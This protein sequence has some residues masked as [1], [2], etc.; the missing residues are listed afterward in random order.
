MAV[1]RLSSPEVSAGRPAQGPGLVLAGSCSQATLAQVGRHEAAHPSLR[2]EPAEAVSPE[3]VVARALAFVVEHR[4]D[5]PLVYSS[6]APEAVAEAQARWGRETLAHRLDG[7]FARLATAALAKGFGRIVV[8]GGETS[9]AVAQALGAP[10]Y[11]IGAEIAPG[12]P[13][14][15][16]TDQPGRGVVLKSGNFGG[17]GFFGEALDALAEGR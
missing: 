11:D 10:A 15:Y 5:Q 7:I 8:A 9:G 17:A 3:K 2:I 1:R 13:S 14:L 4:A 12:V 16:P 6:A